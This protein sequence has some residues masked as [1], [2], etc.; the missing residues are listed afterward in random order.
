M[1]QE[2]PDQAMVPLVCSGHQGGPALRGPGVNGHIR[3]LQQSRH[4]LESTW[5]YKK[6]KT[7]K[8]KIKYN[9]SVTKAGGYYQRSLSILVHLVHIF[10]RL[11]K[12]FYLWKKLK[13]YI[14][15]NWISPTCSKFLFLAASQRILS[16]A[17]I[18]RM[19][20]FLAEEYYFSEKLIIFQICFILAPSF[21]KYFS[22]HIN[23]VDVK[24]KWKILSSIAEDSLFEIYGIVIKLYS[25]PILHN[26]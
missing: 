9:L 12:L 5:K 15:E 1:L 25:A 2:S 10:T 26:F 3:G 20:L 14:I 24:V 11:N 18:T 23:F 6:Y 4:N 7:L 16:P 21:S 8:R 22:L 13:V 17:A 19:N